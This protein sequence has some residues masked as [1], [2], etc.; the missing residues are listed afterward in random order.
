MLFLKK[1]LPLTLQPSPSTA[2]ISVPSKDNV[3]LKK[4]VYFCCFPSLLFIFCQSTLGLYFQS[5][6]CQDSQWHLVGIFNELTLPSSFLP[7]SVQFS[8]SVVSESLRPHRLQHAKLPCPSP[9]PGAC[10]NSC[11][12]SQ[13]CY[14][15]TSSFSNPFSS[16]PQ[17]FP[18]SRSFP[19]SWLFSSGG[20][21]IGASA[22]SSVLPMNAVLAVLC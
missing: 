3:F 16:C 7:S 11:P 22:L 20:Q 6:S 19:M 14:L 1:S 12:L 8:C 21:S 13:W 4:V 2:S 5:C 17:S 18:A 15:T 9:S 10:S